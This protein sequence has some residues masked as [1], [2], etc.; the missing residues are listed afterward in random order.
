[1]NTYPID[2][3]DLPIILQ[4]T[5]HPANKWLFVPD[6]N[7]NGL[8]TTMLHIGHRQ[9]SGDADFYNLD[10]TDYSTY[11]FTVNTRNPRWYAV[12]TAFIPPLLFCLPVMLSYTLGPMAWY[13]LRKLLAGCSFI[14]TAFFYDSYL[15][16]LP[17]L[18]YLTIFDKYIYCLYLWLLAGVLTL[19]CMLWVFRDVV[20]DKHAKHEFVG[21]G[22]SLVDEDQ[23]YLS[24][25]L[26]NDLLHMSMFCG[27]VTFMGLGLLF[28]AW[29]AFLPDV[30]FLIVL[31]LAIWFYFWWVN[32]SHHRIKR[33]HGYEQGEAGGLAHVMS[34][35]EVEEAKGKTFHFDLLL[36]CCYPPIVDICIQECC[37]CCGT[38]KDE[39]EVRLSERRCL[40]A[41]SKS[42][43]IF[44]TWRRGGTEG[45]LSERVA[46]RENPFR[47]LR[48]VR[49]HVQAY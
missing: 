41:R 9:C 4:Q 47:L 11:T 28:L 19:M 13:P 16:Q 1:M 10:G 24:V 32:V 14:S 49:A 46:C 42:V 2:S 38:R 31:I 17:V 44:P 15:R 40:L 39:Y 20:Q 48:S 37:C 23:L 6:G 21:A 29:A 3:Q 5:Q 7:L 26:R 45:S 34:R 43:F 36:C 22:Q 27:I 33:K 18:D 30:V 35:E 12:I 25:N 8:S